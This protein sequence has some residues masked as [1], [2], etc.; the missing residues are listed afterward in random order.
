[1]P[2]ANLR[3]AKR[4]GAF[5]KRVVENGVAAQDAR[6]RVGDQILE[7]NGHSFNGVSHEVASAALS[8]SGLVV[9]LQVVFNPEGMEHLL[10]VAEHASV[11]CCLSVPLVFVP[12]C[13]SPC[14]HVNPTNL[15]EADDLDL[16]MK[17]SLVESELK[18]AELPAHGV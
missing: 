9:R 8:Q 1:M 17:E 7:L 18:T 10:Q 15:Q 6:L 5:V 13:L 2:S 11:C 3:A 12:L 16:K 4:R 14:P